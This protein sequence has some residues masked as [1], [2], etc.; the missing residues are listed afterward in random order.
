MEYLH[1]GRPIFSNHHAGF[2]LERCVTYESLSF[3]ILWN[4]N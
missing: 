4:A 1:S 3:D 2:L